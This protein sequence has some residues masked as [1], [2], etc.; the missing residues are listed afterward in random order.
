ME[1]A[2]ICHSALFL[3]FFSLGEETKTEDLLVC[4]LKTTLPPALHLLE[5]PQCQR[6][7]ISYPSFAMDKFY[8]LIIF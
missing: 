3:W 5:R 7:L 1:G 4:L 8:L 6:T 2:R